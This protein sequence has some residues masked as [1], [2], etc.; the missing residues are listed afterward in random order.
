METCRAAHQGAHGSRLPSPNYRSLREE[1]NHHP[2]NPRTTTTTSDTRSPPPNPRSALRR[3][4]GA[5]VTRAV[6]GDGGRTGGAPV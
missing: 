5:A 2:L 1:P 6:G 4:S 3:R